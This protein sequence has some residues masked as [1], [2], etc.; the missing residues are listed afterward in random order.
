[1]SVVFT[2]DELFYYEQTRKRAPSERDKNIYYNFYNVFDVKEHLPGR[3]R[4]PGILMA[5]V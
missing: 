1:M 4:E 3:D 5:P 2:E